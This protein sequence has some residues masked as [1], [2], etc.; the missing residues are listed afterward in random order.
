[1]RNYIISAIIGAAV[2]ALVSGGILLAVDDDS[3]AQAQAPQVEVDDLG[4][5]VTA[6]LALQRDACDRLEALAPVLNQGNLGPV[7]ATDPM[8]KTRWAAV[9]SVIDKCLGVKH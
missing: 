5:P 8:L 2:G 7:N 9:Q 6:D 1:M 3:S 4:F